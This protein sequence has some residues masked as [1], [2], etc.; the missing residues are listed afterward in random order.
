MLKT[1]R[2]ISVRGKK[3][4]VRLDLDLPQT[5]KGFDASRLEDGLPTLR[6]LLDREADYITIIAHRGRPKGKK[7]RTLSLK[8]V[9]VLLRKKFQKE[10]NERM[11]V[12]ENLRYDSREEKGSMLL[13]RQLAKGQDLFVNDAFAAS[14]RPHTSI[15]CI[16]KLL[17]SV[18]GTHMEREVMALKKVTDEPKRPFILI[19]GGAKLETKL[20]LIQTFKE[21]ADVILVGG[22]LA[23]E[24]Q[25][26][27]VKNRKLI[28]AELTK[29]GKDICDDSVQQFKRF[30]AMAKTVVWN[31]PMGV[32]EDKKHQEGTK[33]IAESLNHSS[34]VY[35]VIGGGDTEAAATKFRSEKH[36]SHVS[37]AGGAML[38]YLATGTLPGIQAL[39]ESQKKYPL[40]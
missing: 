7:V 28:I 1:L 26:H 23:I 34:R 13:A 25:K 18:M 19:L 10:E 2:D 35:T 24:L 37:T 12:L 36:I 14:H 21:K 11:T 5:G 29:D 27:P 32:F 4:L 30:I 33:A 3:V 20:P 15:I 40:E 17:P 9:E 38:D 39:E 22:K 16:P 8:P 6:Y 31:G